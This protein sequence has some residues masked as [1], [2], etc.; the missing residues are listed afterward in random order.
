[1][2]CRGSLVGEVSGVVQYS[3]V[4]EVQ[5]SVVVV[6]QQSVVGEVQQSVVGMRCSS[7]CR[8]R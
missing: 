4:V 8:L 2:R 1:M 3:V 5:L 6:V 7:Q